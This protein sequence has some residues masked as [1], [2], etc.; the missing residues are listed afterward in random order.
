MSDYIIDTC[1]AKLALAIDQVW[2]DD[3]LIWSP[4]LNHNGGA[5]LCGGGQADRVYKMTKT[6]Q[7]I[8]CPPGACSAR[9]NNS[10]H[11]R[12]RFHAYFHTY[13]ARISTRQLLSRSR[14]TALWISTT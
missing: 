6:V 9:I 1:P 11:A 8:P 4:A 7:V 12:L 13:F 14:S 10:M 5:H 3:E 2:A